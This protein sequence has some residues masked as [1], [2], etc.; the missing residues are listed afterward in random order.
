M[1]AEKV[2]DTKIETPMA[3]VW[4]FGQ[5]KDLLLGTLVTKKKRNIG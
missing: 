5:S 3:A 1:L 2:L 4:D